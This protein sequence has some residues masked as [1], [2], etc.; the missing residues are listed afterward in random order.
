MSSSL[1][2]MSKTHLTCYI[3][4][5]LVDKFNSGTVPFCK[6][7][8]NDKN[9]LHCCKV[10]VSYSIFNY[11]ISSSVMPDLNSKIRLSSKTV[12]FSISLLTICSSYSVTRLV[13]DCRN[14]RISS[15][16]F[17]NISCSASLVTTAAFFS[18]K[19]S[20][21]F[22]MTSYSAFLFTHITSFS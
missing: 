11:L 6:F 14:C 17:L 22:A 4:N 20:I 9:T 12:I 3:I 10:S 21:S 18:L 13:C 1:S 7:S 8:M 16:R 5:H 19:A 15:I 2:S